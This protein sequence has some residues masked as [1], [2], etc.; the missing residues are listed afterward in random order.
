MPKA[1][2]VP[3][4]AFSFTL[5]P[6]LLM[7]AVTCAATVGD[8]VVR[9]GWN[10][11]FARRAYVAGILPTAS[12]TATVGVAL[13]STIIAIGVATVVIGVAALIILLIV[14][15]VIALGVILIIVLMVVLIIVTVVSVIALV[16]VAVTLSLAFA[17]AA[18]ARKPLIGRS[19]S[20]KQ[21]GHDY[22]QA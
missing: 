19:A 3:T 8:A 18:S 14:V 21:H 5:V 22:N 2:V 13:R 6:R 4:I 9:S 12:V 15:L 1:V 7:A 10:S 17:L 16:A 20:R 11:M